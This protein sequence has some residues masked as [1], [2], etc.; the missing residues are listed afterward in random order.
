MNTSI[1]LFISSGLIIL[2]GTIVMY[3][4]ESQV[5]DSKI[6]TLLDTSWW[7]VATVTTVGYGDTVPVSDIGRIAAYFLCSF[8]YR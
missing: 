5:P 7:T 2:L 6:K 8:A 1:S 3:S 4:V